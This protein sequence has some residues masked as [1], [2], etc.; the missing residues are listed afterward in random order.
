MRAKQI[1]SVDHEFIVDHKL[2]ATVRFWMQI[3]DLSLAELVYPRRWEGKIEAPISVASVL[4]LL[5]RQHDSVPELAT[6]PDDLPTP[7]MDAPSIADDDAT[8]GCMC[9]DSCTVMF[10][11]TSDSPIKLQPKCTTT[12]GQFLSA[13]E[14]L[15]GQMNVESIC[16]HGAPVGIDHAMEV[17]QVFLIKL[18][19][20]V[21]DEPSDPLEPVVSP[22]L[23]WTCLP[24]E[25]A[26][27]SPP[28]K[29]SKFDVGDCTIPQVNEVSEAQWLDALCW[30]SRVT[31]F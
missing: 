9:V 1:W 7:W 22:T 10:E 26:I 13:H 23:P 28:R 29:V 16:L 18:A 8:Q 25:D 2:Q 21:L 20:P 24:S 4:D 30:V 19:A 17:G 6:D 31:S 11:G 15:V 5:I 3:K 12:I 14:K 27:Q